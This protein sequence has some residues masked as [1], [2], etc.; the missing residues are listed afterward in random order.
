MVTISLEEKPMINVNE[1]FQG[2]I[3]S[4]GFELKATPYTAG[5]LLPGNYTIDT[6]KEEHITATVGEFEVRPPGCDWKTV[7]TGETIMIP[8]KSSFDIKVI[9]PAS[10]ICRYR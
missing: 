2:R 3:K 1:Y 8:S 4:L 5:V 10:Y 6:E 7:R 9:E